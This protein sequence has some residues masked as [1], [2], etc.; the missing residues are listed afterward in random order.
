MN[1]Q[2][3][4]WQI[5]L[6]GSRETRRLLPMAD[7][8]EAMAGAFRALAGGTAVQ[9]LRTV[10]R[11]PGEDDTLYVMPAWVADGGTRALA[12]KLVSLFPGNAEHA[13]ETHQ[14]ALLLFDN[15]SGR[16]LA[17]IEA[18]SVTAIRT[19]AVSAL[20][21]RYLSRADASDLAV[22]GSGVQ[23][24]SHVEAMLA[25]RPIRRV[26]V[27]SRSAAHAHTF[28]AETAGRHDIPIDVMSD[29]ASAVRGADIVCAVTAAQQPVVHGEWLSPGTHVN[30]VGA[31]TPATREL[32]TAAMVAGSF[33][34]DSREA[35]NSESG[36]YLLARADAGAAVAIRGEL[37]DL[38]AERLAGRKVDDEITIFKSLGLAIEDAA[39]ARLV[40]ERA[41]TEGLPGIDFD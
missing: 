18:G 7:C 41:V 28:A 33:W 40:W 29:A 25:V 31:S 24:R 15:A 9:P 17:V 22:L 1:A 2:R 35:V 32:D 5:R 8:I 14:G 13:I 16:V 26:R 39:A 34:V 4:P 11:V 19:A 10:I 3:N 30:A 27:W 38:A 36:D 23:A 21:T 6:I 12:V 37:A 20:A